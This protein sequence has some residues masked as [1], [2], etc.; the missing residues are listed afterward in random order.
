MSIN[1]VI[2]IPAY[3]L[4]IT[5]QVTKTVETGEIKK[6]FFGKEKASKLAINTKIRRVGF[7]IVNNSIGYK[8]SKCKLISQQFLI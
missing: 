7:L 2:F 8:C 3:G 4:P 5:K 6:T 1:R